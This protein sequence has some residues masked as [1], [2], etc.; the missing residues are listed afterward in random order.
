LGGNAPSDIARADSHGGIGTRLL[1]D[2]GYQ[3]N[4]N[5]NFSSLEILGSVFSVP[6]AKIAHQTEKSDRTKGFQANVFHH[7]RPLF[8]G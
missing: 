1:I 8:P 2:R 3:L 4:P 6:V 7:P 5:Q